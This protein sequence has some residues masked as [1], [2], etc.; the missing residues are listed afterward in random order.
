MRGFFEFI[1]ELLFGKKITSVEDVTKKITK[2]NSSAD[3]DALFHK[4]NKRD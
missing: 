4:L 1:I 2:N 3:N